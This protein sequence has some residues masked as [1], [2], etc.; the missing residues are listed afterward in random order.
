[1]KPQTVIIS[2]DPATWRIALWAIRLHAARVAL[3]SGAAEVVATLDDL[4]AWAE[5]MTVKE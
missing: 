4:R 3:S 2:D 1:M 5:G